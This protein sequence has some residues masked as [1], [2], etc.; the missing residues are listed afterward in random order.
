MNFESAI[1]G[2]LATVRPLPSITDNAVN[3][4]NRTLSLF[5]EGIVS[6]SHYIK[7]RGV[8]K[9]L[10]LAHVQR[11]LRLELLNNNVESD[12]TDLVLTY[13]SNIEEGSVVPLTLI[14][15][16]LKQFGLLNVPVCKEASVFVARVVQYLIHDLI[17]LCAISILEEN[18]S[19]IS[20]NTIQLHIT[21]DPVLRSL[22]AGYI[23]TTT[24]PSI[25]TR[26]MR[27]ELRGCISK[28]VT[29]DA[30]VVITGHIESSIS[31]IMALAGDIARNGDRSLVSADDIRLALRA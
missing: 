7:R 19:R 17:E 31:R 9:R 2:I 24:T 11:G 3:F 20:V 21:R 15:K 6:S 25:S 16:F 27:R 12:F 8:G 29:H 4:L 28:R 22:F 18:R 14:N 26:K 13:G 5:V 1:Y 23:Y 30:L 10:T